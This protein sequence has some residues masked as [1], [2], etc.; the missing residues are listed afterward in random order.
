MAMRIKSMVLEYV[1]SY[2]LVTKC[3]RVPPF[4]VIHG[5]KKVRMYTIY[6]NL[7]SDFNTAPVFCARAHTHTHTHTHRVMLP[8]RHRLNQ[9]RET[10]A[11]VSR[12]FF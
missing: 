6:H 2:S 11:E 12:I 4:H 3:Q 10:A 1:T 8:A 5:G 9:S 7:V